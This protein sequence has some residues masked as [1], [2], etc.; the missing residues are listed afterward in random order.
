MK[1]LVGL[2]LLAASPV[3]AQVPLDQ[4]D[5]NRPAAAT[6]GATQDANGNPIANPDAPAGT[7]SWYMAYTDARKA[8]IA[9]CDNDPGH[10][11]NDPDCINAKKADNQVGLNNFKGGLDN[12]VQGAADFFHKF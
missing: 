5:S 11:S 10:L 7:I 4:I 3:L 12:T 8:T 1:R 6:P 2:L 9:R